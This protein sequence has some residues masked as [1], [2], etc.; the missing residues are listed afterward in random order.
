MQLEENQAKVAGIRASGP[1]DPLRNKLPEWLQAK[2]KEVEVA[3][4]LHVGKKIEWQP[5]RKEVMVHVR[6]IVQPWKISERQLAK[7]GDNDGKKE[8]E[9]IDDLQKELFDAIKEDSKQQVLAQAERDKPAKE[10]QAA[11]GE[12]EGDESPAAEEEV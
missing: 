8:S 9:W 12:S 3:L 7:I 2:V 6:A 5:K 10:E 4:R 11:D 1:D